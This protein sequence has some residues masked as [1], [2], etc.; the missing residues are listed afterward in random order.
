MERLRLEELGVLLRECYTIRYELFYTFTLTT[1]FTKK[2]S[3]CKGILCVDSVVIAVR[4]VE[5]L[6][7]VFPV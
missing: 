5:V 4:D 7:F 2:P 3:C 1:N 6:Y